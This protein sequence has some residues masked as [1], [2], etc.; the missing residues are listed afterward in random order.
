MY[1]LK[2]FANLPNDFLTPKSNDFFWLSFYIISSVM[3]LLLFTTS[4]SG[5]LLIWI[6]YCSFQVFVC[7]SLLFFECLFLAL[8]WLTSWSS[9]F[10]HFSFLLHIFHWDVIHSCLS[11]VSV[12][13][14]LI[15]TSCSNMYFQ[16]FTE[17]CCSEMP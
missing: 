1:L 16:L 14:F 8:K 5:C 4:F 17:C 10:I 15:S 12:E 9:V 6:F 11:L 7:I 2:P 13:D 3:N